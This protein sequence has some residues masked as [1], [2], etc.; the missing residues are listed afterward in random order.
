[1]VFA[2]DAIWQWHS[3]QRL[4]GVLFNDC[5]NQ[6]SCPKPVEPEAKHFGRTTSFCSLKRYRLVL[7]LITDG[8]NIHFFFSQVVSSSNN[9]PCKCQH[10]ASGRRLEN[11]LLQIKAVGIGTQT[12]LLLLFFFFAKMRM[13][14]HSMAPVIC[15]WLQGSFPPCQVCDRIVSKCL[16]PCTQANSWWMFIQNAS[17]T[18]MRQTL[19]SHFA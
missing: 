3:F 1:M 13:I 4:C 19:I 10:K 12:K 7:S 18:Q 2:E 17:G 5:T 11:N 6:M 9:Y 15:H 8:H 14:R 16:R